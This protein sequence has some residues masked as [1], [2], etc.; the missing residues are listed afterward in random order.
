MSPYFTRGA[1]ADKIS[2]HEAT[3]A[4]YSFA[5]SA[6][7]R[8]G[9]IACAYAKVLSKRRLSHRPFPEDI[10]IFDNTNPRSLA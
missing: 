4:A 5:T 8:R 2:T 9:A 1:M 3:N 10:G 6:L 7:A